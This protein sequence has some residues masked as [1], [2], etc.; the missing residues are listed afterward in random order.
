MTKL[1]AEVGVLID[2]Y[3]FDTQLTAKQQLEIMVT[4]GGLDQNRP[5]E[6]LQQTVLWDVAVKKFQAFSLGMK[7]RL[8]ITTALLGDPAT[9]ILNEL[10]NCLDVDGIQ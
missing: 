2:S 6:V 9:I 3:A 7:R 8:D 10:F 1:L 4:G 5:E